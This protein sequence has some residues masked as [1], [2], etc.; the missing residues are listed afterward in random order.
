[1]NDRTDF[2]R[3]AEPRDVNAIVGLI[4]ELAEFEKLS[5]LL[6]V[7]PET[8]HPHL[9]GERPVVEAQV[10]QPMARWW[11][12]RSSSPTSP[13]FCPSRGCTWKTSMCAP[14]LR[15]YG[16]GERCCRAS[17]RSPWSAATARFEWSVLDWN[18]NAI[19]FYEKMGATV[20]PTGASAASPVTHCSAS[21]LDPMRRAPP[22]PG[23]RGMD[24][25]DHY[26]ALHGGLRW[27]VP[28]HFNIA[29]GLR[30]ALGARETAGGGDP[31]STK[32]GAAP[33]S[34]TVI[35]RPMPTGCRT[36]SRAW[37]CSAAT[38]SPS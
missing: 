20:L 18:S 35:C 25:A 33:S 8:L 7:T 4:G 24:A 22:R 30:H 34:A 6:Q 10:A 19:R 27:S 11:A 21:G 12:S 26:A 13:P 38:A 9:F 23:S 32:T 5:H 37:A 31:L 14:A 29:A 17:P 15:R 3:A 16:I 36:R 28:E 1:M 2:L